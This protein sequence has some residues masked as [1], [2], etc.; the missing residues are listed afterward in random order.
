MQPS[1]FAIQAV[2][3][4][5]G[6]D[7]EALDRFL[8]EHP[9]VIHEK[10]MVAQMLQQA[11]GLGNLQMLELL[12]RREAE[13]NHDVRSL[14]VTRAIDSALLDNQPDAVRFLLAKGADVNDSELFGQ[15]Y[16]SVLTSAIM[17][18]KLEMVKILVEA[19]ARLDTLDNCLQT[20]ICWARN[21]PAIAAYL[22]SQGA[23][24]PHEVPN[25]EQ[26]LALVRKPPLLD[27]MESKGAEVQELDGFEPGDPP[28]LVML[29]LQEDFSCLFTHGLSDAPMRVPAG[30]EAYQYAELAILI[31]DSIWD[32]S[33]WQRPEFRWAVEWMQRIARHPFENDTWL[34]GKW[35]IISNEDPP[36][37]L[38]EFT[39][40][41]CWLLLGEKDPLA[42]AELP[43]G[44]S[45]CFYTL[46]PI[47]T[48]ER[49]LALRE[50]LVALLERFAEQDVSVQLDPDRPSVV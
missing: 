19:G 6:G 26:I 21:K 13:L 20:P 12:L 15:P 43:D 5:K 47:H 3:L 40:M 2:L 49:D 17:L 22:R 48:A 18:D 27:W 38:S 16:S 34:G 11:A 10:V 25:Y 35:T 37:P 4:A 42:R 44:K 50:G 7:T 24:E 23:I 1:D 36:Q 31:E 9:K 8:T 28:S 30:G 32:E 45:V 14:S 33:T 46:M 41:T 29:C 39:Q